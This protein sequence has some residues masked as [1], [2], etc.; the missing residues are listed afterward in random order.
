LTET[1]IKLPADVE[2]EDK[3][4]FGLTARQLVILG[5]SALGA[6]VAFTLFSSLLAP[7]LA[8]ALATPLVLVGIALALGRRDGVSGDRLALHAMSHVV[9][10]RRRVLAPEGLAAAPR[11]VGALDLPVRR[12]WHSGL[13]ELE[14]G[15]F[16]LL[17]SA[18]GMSFALRSEV[19]QAAL[20]EGFAR[21]LNALTE[22]V[23]IVVRSVALDLEARATALEALAPS[24][25]Q[26]ALAH[27]ACGHA[28]FLRELARGEGVRRREILLIL[29]TRVRERDAA[30]VTLGRRADEAAALLA[31]AAVRLRTLDGEQAGALLARALDPPGPP[32]GVQLEGEVHAC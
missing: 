19:E 1:Q 14:G 8:A 21:F 28:R 2:L 3:L 22:P 25:P 5:A 32:V 12:V 10:P 9:S 23:Q 7:P 17:L 11:G 16:C 4:A 20:V 29:T 30:K 18:S 13:V 24:L 31:G 15:A 27:A 26:L 6:Y